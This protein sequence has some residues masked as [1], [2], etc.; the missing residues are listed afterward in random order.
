MAQQQ[1]L[2]S[3]IN[4]LL[5]GENG[6]LRL[7]RHTTDESSAPP[8]SHHASD[9]PQ[10]G[11]VP[12][13]IDASPSPGTATTDAPAPSAD[14]PA[15]NQVSE[16]APEPRPGFFA[17]WTPFGRR[18]INRDQAIIQLQQGFSTLTSLMSAVKNSLESSAARQ[19]ELARYLSHLPQVMESV[20]ES[21]R[22]HQETLDAIR[23]QLEHQSRQQETLGDILQR[24]GQT[25]GE[26]KQLMTELNQRVEQL[27]DADHQIAVNLSS[28]G[29]AM[30]SVGKHSAAGTEVLS[31]MRDNM[32]AH[33]E[34]LEKLLQRQGT[35]FAAMVAV[36]IFIALASL[37]GVCVLGYL[38]LTKKM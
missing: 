16:R 38:I 11:D 14:L 8:D 21:H 10:S 37:A 5:R 18:R 33:D 35:R 4:K 19:D 34:R 9:M 1:S 36:T 26:S 32:H 25:G 23:V 2:L 29:S 27:Q 30:E 24:L 12:H 28:V 3:K 20:P 15:L 6:A 31:Q 22:L 17:S 7:M 13:T